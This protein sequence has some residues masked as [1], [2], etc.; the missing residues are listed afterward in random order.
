MSAPIRILVTG[1]A[2]IIGAHVCE[3]PA[4]SGEQC[5][6]LDH[7]DPFYARSVKE[8]NLE[9]LR[10]ATGFRFVESDIVRD[11]LPIDG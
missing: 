4:P 10:R 6:G 8:R 2:G 3:A 1:S 11:A 9:G 7:F 5:V